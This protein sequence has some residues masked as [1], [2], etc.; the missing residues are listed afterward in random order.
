MA[1]DEDLAHSLPAPPP[2]AP[3][4][5]E[6][7]IEVA[8]R[9]FDGS[10]RAPAV[11]G[12]PGRGWQASRPQLGTLAGVSLALLV[13]VPLAVQT[14]NQRSGT[15]SPPEP[16]GA[17]PVVSP[18][19]DDVE[20][21]ITTS[22][23]EAPAAQPAREMPEPSRAEDVAIDRAD[24]R[25]GAAASSPVADVQAESFAAPPPPDYAAAPPPAMARA[26]PVI[27]PTA[28]PAPPS[29]P[30]AAPEATPAPL[31]SR[32]GIAARD[33]VVTASRASGQ[34]HSIASANACT[35]DDPRRQLALCRDVID[36]GG[37][38]RAGRAAARILDG[39]SL[40]WQGDL[41]GAAAAFDRAIAIAPRSGV[42]YLNRGLIRQRQGDRDGAIAD[43]DRAVAY[44][45]SSAQ[46]LDRRARL[47][48]QHDD[49]ARAKPGNARA[50]NA[51]SRSKPAEQ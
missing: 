3:A 6:A 20:R 25:S 17:V 27:T 41:D 22:S 48:L 15:L 11:A 24:P 23:R 38:G 26:A 36:A 14:L 4:R 35:I 5:R 33:V 31:A 2:P 10:E 44:A 9:R 37:E 19:A 42:A 7:A 51:E 29:Q 47:G 45:P 21:K 39:L 46:A 34:V 40:A 50:N 28:P 49:T 32:R 12:R 8:L 43:L 30:A 13:G 16:A 1:G 18:A